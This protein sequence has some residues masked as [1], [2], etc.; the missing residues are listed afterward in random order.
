MDETIEEIMKQWNKLKKKDE[1]LLVLVGAPGSG[2]SQILRRLEVRNGWKYAEAKDL[3]PADVFSVPRK[4]RADWAKEH[5]TESIVRL[6]GPVT[7]IDSIGL[8][9][10]PVYNMHPMDILREISLT[11]PLIAGWTGAF[12]GEKL[13]LEYNGRK[14]FHVYDVSDK[15]HIF[16]L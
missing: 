7:I 1:R 8:L 4:E 3:L 6:G 10:A 2:K 16:T 12:D 11:H 9:F 5:M 15:D 13:T 14:D